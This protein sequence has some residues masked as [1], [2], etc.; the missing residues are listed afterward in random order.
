MTRTMT[1]TRSEL[2][3]LLRTLSVS[4]EPVTLS[5]GKQSNFY[6]DCKQTLLHP[7][8]MA[9]TGTVLVDIWQELG[10]EIDAVGGPALG[11]CPMTCAFVWTS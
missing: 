5:S 6:V 11:A 2:L 10:L 9:L 8:G 1:R 3:D 4:H 7:D